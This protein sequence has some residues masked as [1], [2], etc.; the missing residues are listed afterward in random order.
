[1]NKRITWQR[2][3]E[4]SLAVGELVTGETYEVPEGLA[5]AWIEQGAATLAPELEPEAAATLE[6][7][8]LDV[9]LPTTDTDDDA[10]AGREE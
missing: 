3:N 5:N 2:P 1:M 6:T 10:H 8:G 9:E 4:T 7:E